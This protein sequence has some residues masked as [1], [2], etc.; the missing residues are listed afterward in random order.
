MTSMGS[1]NAAYGLSQYY[2]DELVVQSWGAALVGV[3]PHARQSTD[4]ASERAIFA[5]ALAFSN[6]LRARYSRW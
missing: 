5:A 2:E 4:A 6:F 1:E 3:A